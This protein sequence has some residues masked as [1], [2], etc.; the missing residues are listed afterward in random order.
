MGGKTQAATTM[1]HLLSAALWMV[2][3]YGRCWDS[4]APALQYCR[5]QTG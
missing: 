1:L 5:R 4:M 3:G 2:L